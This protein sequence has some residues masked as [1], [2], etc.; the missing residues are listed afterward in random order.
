MVYY[1]H[2]SGS[3]S[4]NLEYTNASGV[5]PVNGFSGHLSGSLSINFEYTNAS[6]VGPLNGLL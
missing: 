3:L 1:G 5:E 2:L 6:G 4:I